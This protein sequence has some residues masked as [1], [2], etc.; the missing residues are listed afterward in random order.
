MSAIQSRNPQPRKNHRRSVV[1]ALFGALRGLRTDAAAHR[2]ELQ[3]VPDAEALLTACQASGRL[4]RARLILRRLASV[5]EPREV[6]AF[7]Q[8]L[9]LAAQAADQLEDQAEHE[10][11]VTGDPKAKARW[12]RALRQSHDHDEQ[13]IAALEGQ[14]PR[15]LRA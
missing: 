11:L 9:Q 12:L 8:E 15:E 14:Q 3:V 10:A 5:I 7:C 1:T 6:P 4:G 13:L 2:R